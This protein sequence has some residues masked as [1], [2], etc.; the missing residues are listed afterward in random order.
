MKLYIKYACCAILIIL[1]FGFQ[2]TN[3]SKYK[4]IIF[5]GSDWCTNCRRLEKNIL[6][7]TLFLKQL[8]KMSVNI[9]RIDFPQRKKIAKSTQEYNNSI[10]DKYAFNG[11][12]PTIILTEN[13][14]ISFQKISYTNQTPE[15]IL[16]Q[17]KSKIEVLK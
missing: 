8:E 9:E 10:A 7:D 17:I 15:E 14:T 12:F 6:N 1:S 3:Q 4:L 16:S 11:D 5:E 2:K 13:E